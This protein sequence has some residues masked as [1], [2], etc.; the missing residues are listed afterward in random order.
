[1]FIKYFLNCMSFSVI[2]FKKVTEVK[3]NSSGFII[4]FMFINVF[5]DYELH[6]F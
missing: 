2:Y 3:E 1:M 6:S 4:D 5:L